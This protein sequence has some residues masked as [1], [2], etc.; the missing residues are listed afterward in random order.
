MQFQVKRWEG[1]QA[2]VESELRQAL[3]QEGLDAYAW[4]NG[5]GDMYA[6]HTHSYHKVIY[7]VRGAITW[8]LP[9]LGQE[10]ETRAGDRLELPRGLL[11]AARVGPQGVTCLEAHVD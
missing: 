1:A 9:D 8:I 2:P 7:V 6:A 5:P 3:R 4:S 11:H 10:L